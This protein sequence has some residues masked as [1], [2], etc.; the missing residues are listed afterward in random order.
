MYKITNDELKHKYNFIINDHVD[1]IETFRTISECKSFLR[2][3]NWPLT[4]IVKVEC[5][6]QEFYIAA[7]Y[8]KLQYGTITIPLDSFNES[9]RD[10][11]IL[12]VKQHNLKSNQTAHN[13]DMLKCS[14]EYR[15]V[16]AEHKIRIHSLSCK[17]HAL[18]HI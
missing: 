4:S 12:D 10:V 1:V 15:V 17:K 2:K 13:T 14:C 8:D 9:K 16:D 7:D 11:L 5:R 6:F 18:Q 3:I